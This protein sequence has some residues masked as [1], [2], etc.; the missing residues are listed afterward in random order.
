MNDIENKKK[1]ILKNNLSK[2]EEITYEKLKENFEKN[3]MIIGGNI[4]YENNNGFLEYYSFNQAKIR[5]MNLFY[6]K[7]DEEREKV[8]KKSFLEEWLQD[9][10]RRQYTNI[11]FIPNIED[12]SNETYNLFKGFNAEKYNPGYELPIEIINEKIDPIIVHLNLLTSGYAEYLLKWL[13]FIIQNPGNK[14]QIAPL[15]RDQGETFSEGG[16]TGKNRFFEYF[17]NKILGKQYF[18]VIANNKEL[19]TSFNSQL[20]GKLF[21]LVEETNS[22][23]NHYNQ[24][25]LKSTITKSTLNVNKKNVAQYTVNDHCNYIFCSNNKNPLPIKI[26]NRRH[27]VFDTNPIK[28]GD[29]EYFKKLNSVLEDD[30]TTWAF[31]QYLLK[32]DTYKSQIEFSN[33]IPDTKAY[34]EIRTLNAP[35]H[36]KWIL[37]MVKGKKLEEMSMSELYKKFCDW[38]KKNNESKEEKLMSLTAFGILINNNIV[39]PKIDENDNNNDT[40][41]EIQNIGEKRKSN[42][43]M[44][45]K[46]N[47]ENVVNG[48]KNIYLLE[49]N[50]V[51]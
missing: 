20:E 18:L 47:I 5:Y 9:S 6:Y 13:A 44:I 17:G 49:K 31:Y 28:R 32:L 2:T 21:V 42:G 50:F 19:Y 38:V 33:N 35:I 43:I 30:L 12:C 26:G 23:D 51:Y 27:P 11:D 1:L 40:E 7:Y 41:Y 48:L 29:I 4:V 16:G 22:K 3:N 46:W 10:D 39:N 45:M 15:I 36:L 37:S 25:P 14:T 8:L 34:L 24:D